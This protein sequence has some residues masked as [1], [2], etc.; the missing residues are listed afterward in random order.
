MPAN[1]NHSHMHMKRHILIPALLASLLGFIAP[2][3]AQ[4]VDHAMSSARELYASGD[5]ETAKEAYQAAYDAAPAGS[6]A[7][8][9]ATLEL[10]SLL[11]EQ[12]DYSQAEAKARDALA[13]AKTLKLDK[14]IGRLMLTLGH[15]EASRGK[16]SSAQTTLSICAK[17]AQESQ[18]LNV[19]ALCRVSLRFVKQLRG[20]PVS[21]TEFNRDLE[22]L[23]KSGD[24]M[25]VGTALAKSSEGF[26]RAGD[27]AHALGLLNQ[28]Q[29]RFVAAG[30]LPAQTRNKLRRAELYQEMGRYADAEKEL[31]GLVLAFK[32]MRNKPSLVTA[33]SL[34]GRQAEQAGDMEAAESHFIAAVKLAG[35]MSNPTLV[36]NSELAACE[37][38]ART[39]NDRAGALCKSAHARFQKS[40]VPD[41]AARAVVAGARAAHVRG[42][43]RTAREGYIAAAAALEDR[44]Y[45]DDDRKELATQ[46]VNLCSIEFQL[47]SASAFGRCRD[48]VKRLEQVK[49]QSSEVTGMLGAAHLTA[50]AAAYKLNKAKDAEKHLTTSILLLEKVGDVARASDA[51]LRLGRLQMRLQR[52]EAAAS[53][54]RSIE[55]SKARPEL[56]QTTTQARIQYA[57]YLMDHEK[58]D[59]AAQ[60]LSPA[61]AAAQTAKESGTV[62][63]IY[64][65]QARV[66]L[67]QGKKDDAIESLKAGIVAA[68]SAGDKELIQSLEANLS[69]FKD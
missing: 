67:K 66:Q 46:Y 17:S 53:L 3:A 55:L 37:F 5:W 10:A 34:N 48:A 24:D 36:A 49:T 58:W 60:Q 40:G 4:D 39:S 14:A 64:S 15:I 28:A 2:A 13:Q 42:D 68:K 9:E 56:A 59:L 16:L 61:L 31:D 18:D 6:V 44:I 23:K 12:G 43:L 20:Q 47:E 26:A 45:T 27:Y 52:D 35:T 50:G 69:K 21:D 63:W 22:L 29:E 32:N 33:Y 19:A 62:A 1:E 38:Y 8:A 54:E 25:L 11:W 30:S 41:L 57:Q 65:A 51:Y 7:R